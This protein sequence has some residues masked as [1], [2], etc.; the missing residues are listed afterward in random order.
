MRTQKSLS[1]PSWVKSASEQTQSPYHCKETATDKLNKIVLDENC[2]HDGLT[3]EEALYLFKRACDKGVKVVMD[4][5]INKYAHLIDWQSI[6][7]NARELDTFKHLVQ[8]HQ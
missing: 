4:K 1:I 2:I 6:I 7:N 3:Q 5:V 8:R